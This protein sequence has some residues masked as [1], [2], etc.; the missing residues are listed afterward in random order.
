MKQAKKHLLRALA[1]AAEESV[2]QA[3]AQSAGYAN[4][5]AM[6]AA[7]TQA[8]FAHPE[9]K[10]ATAQVHKM[11]KAAMPLPKLKPRTKELG[12]LDGH[13]QAPRLKPR[14]RA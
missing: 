9:V 12:K 8:L 14:K 1:A 6:R 5:D 11:A 4:A 3:V 2:E 7:L 13:V 10:L